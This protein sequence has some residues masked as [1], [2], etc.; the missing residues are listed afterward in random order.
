MREE[1]ERER[2]NWQGHDSDG[3]GGRGGIG[4]ERNFRQYQLTHE[5]FEEEGAITPHSS[6]PLASFIPLSRCD[7]QRDNGTASSRK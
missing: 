5:E 4:S 2:N 6:R 3:N 7:M 1:K